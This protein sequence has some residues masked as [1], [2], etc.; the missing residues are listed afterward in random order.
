MSY[1]NIIA[2]SE[3]AFGLE[4]KVVQDTAFFEVAS[5][6]GGTKVQF[7][8]QNVGERNKGEDDLGENLNITAWLGEADEVNDKYMVPNQ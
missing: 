4:L 5:E 2:V 1:D 8:M 7:L 3:H 6:D